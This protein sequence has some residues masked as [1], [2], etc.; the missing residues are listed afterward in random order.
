MSTTETSII[1]TYRGSCGPAPGPSARGTADAPGASSALGRRG[2]PGAPQAA[3]TARPA[4]PAR[5]S[6]LPKGACPASTV[7][8]PDV[9]PT[10]AAAAVGAGWRGLAVTEEPA[11]VPA[12][13]RRDR[14][15][16][17]PAC[18]RGAVRRHLRPALI[19]T[20]LAV[21]AAA[22]L[23]AHAAA[24]VTDALPTALRRARP[25]AG[26]PHTPPPPGWCP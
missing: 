25:P 26:S 18:R 9:T 15:A 13:G 24:G 10:A 17:R 12:P 5:R 23:P 1:P 16:R 11:P 19:G 3:Q 22:A 20:L 7:T 21:A 4:G 14:R 6:V 8:L 2:A